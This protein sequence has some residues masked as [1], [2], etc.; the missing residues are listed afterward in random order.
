MFCFLKQPLD[1]PPTIHRGDSSEVWKQKTAIKWFLPDHQNND[2]NHNYFF[3][4]NTG[5]I[6][7]TLLRAAIPIPRHQ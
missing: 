7:G 6:A 5:A 1:Q 4:S 3:S 2:L